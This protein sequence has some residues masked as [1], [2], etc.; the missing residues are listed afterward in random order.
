VVSPYGPF[1]PFT[2]TNSNALCPNGCNVAGSL[3]G[4]AAA[5]CVTN[6]VVN[7]TCPT[8]GADPTGVLDSTT[9]IQNALNNANGYAVRLPAG[10]Y[11]VNLAALN[12][13]AAG[14]SFYGDGKKTVIQSSM[15]STNINSAS[16]IIFLANDNQ[17]VHDMALQGT[18]GPTCLL[19]GVATDFT[20]SGRQIYN[21]QVTKVYGSGI[22]VNGTSDSAHDNYVSDTWFGIIGV[23]THNNVGPN[24]RIVGGW[25]ANNAIG[26]WT[27]SGDFGLLTATGASYTTTVVTPSVVSG[28]CTALGNLRITGVSSGALSAVS[29]GQPGICTSGTVLSVPGGTG[30]QLTVQAH[31]LFTISTAG[32]GYSVTGV[33]PTVVSGSCTTTGVLEYVASAGVITQQV[34]DSQ[35]TGCSIGTFLS[36]PGGTGGQIEITSATGSTF[37]DCVI[38]EGSSYLTV[39]NNPTI[40]DCGQSGVYAGGNNDNLLS[41]TV[42]GNVI[43]HT[44]NYG[45]DLSVAT[46]GN[47]ASNVTVTGNTSIDSESGSCNFAGWDHSTASGNTCQES[48]NYLA[49]WGLDSKAVGSD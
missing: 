36:V 35:P 20:H 8:Y 31:G 29:W 48:S 40:T 43:T 27:G 17:S 9:A 10:T 49:Y 25:K 3:T 6:N 4:T 1:G 13:P 24:N 44:R 12:V 33:T 11:K 47:T 5:F 30:G 38:G 7:P 28:S 18:G 22:A 39:A 19:D 45:I 46:A 32:S 41:P 34:W 14:Q 16:D 26:P 42:T 23:G 2:V 21:M 37:W 15:C